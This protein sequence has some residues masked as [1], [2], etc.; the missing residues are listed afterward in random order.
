MLG[1]CGAPWQRLAL[2]VSFAHR[3]RIPTRAQTC[4]GLPP[5]APASPPSASMTSEGI[6]S[7]PGPLQLSKGRQDMLSIVSAAP[8]AVF[9]L[10]FG[11]RLSARQ[12]GGQEGVRPTLD[13]KGDPGVP[14]SSASANCFK[15]HRSCA[16]NSARTRRSFSSADGGAYCCMRCQTSPRPSFSAK[17]VRSIIQGGGDTQA[18]HE[19]AGD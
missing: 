5:G 9:N 14:C 7:M 18:L 1:L 16:F 13:S 8:P 10:C 3:T 4:E 15:Q 12:A 2:A 11:L 19:S 6:P 17:G